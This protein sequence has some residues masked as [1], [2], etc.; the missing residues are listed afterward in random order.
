MRADYKCIAPN[1]L[2]HPTAHSFSQPYLLLLAAMPQPLATLNLQPPP[3]ENIEVT[4]GSRSGS[5]T[6]VSETYPPHIDTAMSTPQDNNIPPRPS[7]FVFS[8]STILEIPGRLAHPPSIKSIGKQWAIAP[9]IAVSLDD[10]LTMRHLSPLSLKDFEQYLLFEEYGAE[11]L[12][13]LLWLNDYATQFHSGGSPRRLYYS[14]A[15]TKATFF[16]SDSQYEL[17]LAAVR[18]AEFYSLV[19][20]AAP[21]KSPAPPHP[22]S[23]VAIRGDVEVMLRTSARRFVQSRSHN[24]STQ[25]ALC[26][27]FGGLLTMA[28]ALAPLMVSRFSEHNRYI[29]FGMIP[30]LWL[31]FT[32]FLSSINGV[33]LVLYL[34]GGS[35]QLHPFE[36]IRPDISAPVRHESQS[37]YQ[38]SLVTL[39]STH[40]AKVPPMSSSASSFVQYPS[41]TDALQATRPPGNFSAPPNVYVLPQI[42]PSTP[43]MQL[44]FEF[45]TAAFIPS[46]EDDCAATS[47]QAS[48]Y[49]ESTI[50]DS[51]SAP[52][53]ATRSSTTKLVFDFD[54][55]PTKTLTSTTGPPVLRAA[56]GKG[57]KRLITR[58]FGP[59]TR[60]RNP[61]IS[62]AQWEVAIRS[63]VVAATFALTVSG[64]L[65][66]API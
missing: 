3:L 66:A 62:R 5:P 38:A 6:K 7:A 42:R 30:P 17:N 59:V 36:L 57:I 43:I 24:A 65:V 11:N 61:V 39:D 15:R 2:G 9:E 32:V 29:R 58:T 33:C 1:R 8:A 21:G 50:A 47:D 13:F 60:V 37:P 52:S 45:E 16:S 49:G 56:G 27:T 41:A 35:R 51:T 64:V 4:D 53:A 44:R 14:V 34:M 18:I 26:I 22:D 54:A 25:R 10:I 40:D 31:G 23:F 46:Q 63:M 55:L 19:D 48:T 20:S 28:I 12:Y